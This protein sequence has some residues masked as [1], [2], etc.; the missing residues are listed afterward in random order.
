MTLDQL[1]AIH[2]ADIEAATWA[3]FFND[4]PMG[5]IE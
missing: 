4:V 2:R 3:A 1:A 5:W